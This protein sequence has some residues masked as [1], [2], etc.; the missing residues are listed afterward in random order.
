MLY[1]GFCGVAVGLLSAGGRVG[2]W[3]GIYFSWWYLFFEMVLG[4]GFSGGLVV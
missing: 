2:W 3:V 1:I 4:V